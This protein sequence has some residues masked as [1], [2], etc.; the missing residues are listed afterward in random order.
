M[1]TRNRIG[2]F[3][4]RIEALRGQRL[5]QLT[6]NGLT[7]EGWAKL[8]RIAA[9]NP[10]QDQTD[11]R[12]RSGHEVSDDVLLQFLIE[13]GVLEPGDFKG[14]PPGRVTRQSR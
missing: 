10:V 11:W 6:R 1:A 7:D 9:E 2:R 5:S 3:T 14:C 13:E 8:E 12:S 4:E